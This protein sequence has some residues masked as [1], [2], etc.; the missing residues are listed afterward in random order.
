M[1]MTKK[2]SIELLSRSYQLAWDNIRFYHTEDIPFERNPVEVAVDATVASVTIL[3]VAF[4][5]CY[6][7]MLL[8]L[9]VLFRC[10]SMCGDKRWIENLPLTALL[11]HP[12]SLQCDMG[13]SF[14]VTYK[15][16][17]DVENQEYI[18]IT[19]SG[20][21]TDR[22]DSTTRGPQD[23]NRETGL[24]EDITLLDLDPQLPI[25]P[26]IAAGDGGGVPGGEFG[27]CREATGTEIGLEIWESCM[28]RTQGEVASD[29][30]VGNCGIVKGAETL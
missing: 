19:H 24:P 21:S 16:G 15:M 29:G 6:H 23:S 1:S 9:G 18:I 10:L 30:K 17:R 14:P 13:K 5:S 2:E 12:T 22:I 26:N 20:Q 11:V 25:I 27:S 3:G 28:E 4:W 8:I 7:A